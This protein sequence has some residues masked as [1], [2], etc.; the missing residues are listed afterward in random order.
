MNVKDNLADWNGE[1]RVT[2]VCSDG[3]KRHPDTFS[4]VS[5]ARH[6]A[7]WGHFCDVPHQF[8]VSTLTLTTEVFDA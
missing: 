2:V 7:D 8:R 4:K 6:W 5:D 1:T 3:V